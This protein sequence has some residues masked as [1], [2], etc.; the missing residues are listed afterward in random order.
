MV[1]QYLLWGLAVVCLLVG[2]TASI[3]ALRSTGYNILWPWAVNTSAAAL[4][5]GTASFF[6]FGMLAAEPGSALRIV[7]AVWTVLG[8]IVVFV[9]YRLQM[10][11]MRRGQWE[12]HRRGMDTWPGIDPAELEAWARSRGLTG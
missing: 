10:Y 8:P 11:F 9:L 5:A 1:L 6:V 4:A 3:Q 12:R 2:L 7:C